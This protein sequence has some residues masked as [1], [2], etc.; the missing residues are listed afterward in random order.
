[1][2]ADDLRDLRKGLGMSQQELAD[3]IGMSRKAISEMERAA[4]PIER[5]TE[6]AVRYVALLHELGRSLS[7]S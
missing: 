1:M 6:L 3:K 4:A 2:Q 7:V 5:R